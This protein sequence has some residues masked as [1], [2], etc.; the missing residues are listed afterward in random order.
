M[1]VIGISRTAGLTGVAQTAATR[2]VLVPCSCLLVPP[3]IMAALRKVNLL[4]RAKP[5]AMAL[6]IAAIYMCL[7]GA[8][9]AALAVFPQVWVVDVF[10]VIYIYI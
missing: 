2:C 10:T 9:P 8:L 3:V 7:Q 5:A 1:K 6:E 4:P